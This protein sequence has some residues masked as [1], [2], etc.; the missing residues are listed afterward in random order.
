MRHLWKIAAVAVC[1][2]FASAAMGEDPVNMIENPGFEDGV[3]Q[4]W[5]KYGA[6]AV[7]SIVGNRD[8]HTGKRALRIDVAGPGENFWSAGLQYKPPGVV[9]EDGVLYTW[10][11][12]AKS[13][14]PVEVNLKPELAQ[15][16]W[17]GFGAKRAFLV[18]EY[19]EYWTEWT[20]PND[21]NPAS[22]TLHVQFDKST[23]WI[24]DAR[25][26]K[27]A[28][29]PFGGEPQSVNPSGKAAAVWASLK[30]R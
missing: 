24:D 15:D 14:P 3:L 19:Q 28:Y 17:T 2:V 7:T 26:Y 4:P 1:F 23:I 20:P 25:W 6:N 16:P 9:F 27:G 30:A 18:E 11:F 29:T 22:L 8:V 5:N 12:F 21:V 10:S 13:D